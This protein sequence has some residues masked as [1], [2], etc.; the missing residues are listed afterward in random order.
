MAAGLDDLTDFLL[1]GIALLGAQGS[2]CL[3]PQISAA[4]RITL[5]SRITWHAFL[6]SLQNTN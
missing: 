3:A 6:H 5:L 1:A 4:V 2:Y